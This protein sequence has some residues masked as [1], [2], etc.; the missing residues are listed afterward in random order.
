MVLTPN[1][2]LNDFIHVRHTVVN[3]EVKERSINSQ[4]F[5]YLEHLGQNLKTAV[6]FSIICI[7]SIPLF[8]PLPVRTE[9]LEKSLMFEIGAVSQW[10]LASSEYVAP[11][12]LL[13]NPMAHRFSL[14]NNQTKETYLCF[15]CFCLFVLE[16]GERRIKGK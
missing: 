6:K 11:H 16:G 8:H 2:F 12:W 7:E 1:D 15:G 10:V 4:V 14:W 3:S 5:V 9:F 13:K